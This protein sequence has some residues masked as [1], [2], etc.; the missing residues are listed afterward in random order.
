MA[1]LHKQIKRFVLFA[2]A[3][4]LFLG[5]SQNGWGSWQGEWE[6]VINAAKK[7]GKVVVSIPASAE[8]RTKMEAAFEKRFAGI[9]LE[10]FPSR[11]SRQLRR[12]RDELKA[13]EVAQV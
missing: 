5:F 6:K 4:I 10:L 9:D 7:E 12:I 2:V 1:H 3:G 13:G 8:L 11:A